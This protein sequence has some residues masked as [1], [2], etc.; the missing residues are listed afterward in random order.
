M[1]ALY[2]AERRLPP[3]MQSTID[4]IRMDMD[5]MLA[6]LRGDIQTV[7]RHCVSSVELQRTLSQ[8]FADLEGHMSESHH[9]EGHMSVSAEQ[10]QAAQS[11]RVQFN[12]LQEQ[13]NAMV[14]DLRTSMDSKI[15][16]RESSF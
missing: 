13:Q 15:T 1:A 6:T 4:V 8:L 3:D 5:S 10:A 9:L 2:A 16:A 7:Q 11:S 14:S 12:A